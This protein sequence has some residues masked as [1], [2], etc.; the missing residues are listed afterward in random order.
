MVREPTWLAAAR[1]IGHWHDLAPAISGV[2]KKITL[3]AMRMA[4]RDNYSM[5]II[6]TA[7]EEARERKSRS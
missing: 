3:T 4:A 7:T 1:V 5:G 6:G 2:L